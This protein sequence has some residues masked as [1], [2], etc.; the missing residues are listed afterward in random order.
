MAIE[1]KY[2]FDLSVL[3]SVYPVIISHHRI[4]IGTSNAEN[5][6]LRSFARSFC[7]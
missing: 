1:Y 3:S 2:I 7:T 6:P 5:S 4:E